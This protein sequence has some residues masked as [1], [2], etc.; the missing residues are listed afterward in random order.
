M[1]WIQDVGHAIKDTPRRIVVSFRWKGRARNSIQKILETLVGIVVALAVYAI[2][3]RPLV[4]VISGFCAEW[5]FFE[6][7]CEPLGLSR[8]YWEGGPRKGDRG[9]NGGYFWLE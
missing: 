4:A 9:E 6:W 1:S 2:F 3:D 7:L 5:V 8:Y